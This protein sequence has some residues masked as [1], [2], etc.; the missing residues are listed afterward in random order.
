VYSHLI[1][2]LESCLTGGFSITVWGPALI[3]PRVWWLAVPHIQADSIAISLQP[4]LI[5]ICTSTRY[6]E[7]VIEV[8][9]NIW[10][11]NASHTSWE[12]GIKCWELKEERKMLLVYIIL[13]LCI[14]EMIFTNSEHNGLISTGLKINYLYLHTSHCACLS[15]YVVYCKN[16]VQTVDRISVL[17]SAHTT[18]DIMKI[19]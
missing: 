4:V 8:P 13:Q 19:V 10:L 16:L 1:H 15:R 2:N 7:L 12:L 5:S 3:A 6:N 17:A 18:T 9:C 14:K 11:R